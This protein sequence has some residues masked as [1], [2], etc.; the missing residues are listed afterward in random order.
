M[1]N[2]RSGPAAWVGRLTAGPKD[3]LYR[4]Y[5]RYFE[6]AAWVEGVLRD[7]DETFRCLFVGDPRLRQYIQQRIFAGEPREIAVRRIRIGALPSLLRQE[8]SKVDL[9]V[10]VLPLATRHMFAGSA[11]A[12]L[13]DVWVRQVVDLPDT[14]EKLAPKLHR[15]PRGSGRLIRKH[16][17]TMRISRDAGDFEFFYTRMFL[18]HTQKQYGNLANIESMEEMKTF[19]DQGFL[20]LVEEEG[21]PIAGSLCLMD[22]TTLVYRRMGVLDADETHIR[23]GAQMAVYNFS[24]QLALEKRLQFFDL[25]KSRA[26][27]YDGVYEHKR[28][29]GATTKHDVES[30]TWVHYVPLTGSA[31]AAAFFARCPVIVEQDDHLLGVLGW[32]RPEQPTAEEQHELLEHNKAP[33]MTGLLV[34]TSGGTSPLH[35]RWDAPPA[36]SDGASHD[37]P[38]DTNA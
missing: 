20:L 35:L 11:S 1:K 22:D 34:Y 8:T 14:W 16:G 9:C 7:S 38:H 37:A 5:T 25:M 3:A 19:F 29:W 17:L 32:E 2:E 36:A 24:L 31:R 23:K 28:R 6:R 33:G 21:R 13:G 18:P 12:L 30:E 26:C 15:T 27:L 4:L 10:A